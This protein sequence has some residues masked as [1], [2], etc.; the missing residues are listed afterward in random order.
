M[1]KGLNR[2]VTD[3][4]KVAD[5]N[6][7]KDQQD[8]PQ[9]QNDQNQQDQP[10]SQDQ[11]DQSQQEQGQ[12]DQ[13]QQGQNDHGQNDQ[14]QGQPQDQ[15]KEIVDVITNLSDQITNLKYEIDKVKNSIVDQ[16]KFETPDLNTTVLASFDF[17]KKTAFLQIM[18]ELNDVADAVLPYNPKLSNRIDNVMDSLRSYNKG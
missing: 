6:D 18:D 3:L 5:D 11:N 16:S 8:Q 2:L 15:L 17:M 10:Q 9:D 7:Q 1:L 4:K 12:D 13:S 14:Q